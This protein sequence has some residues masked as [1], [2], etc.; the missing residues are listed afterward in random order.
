MVQAPEKISPAEWRRLA[1]GREK[2]HRPQFRGGQRD[3]LPGSVDSAW[4]ANV[5]RILLLLQQAGDVLEIEREPFEFS[6]PL[7][8][9]TNYYLPDFRVVFCDSGQDGLSIATTRFV[10]VKG[11][12]TSKGKTQLKR[13]AKYYPEIF[14][15]MLF[16]VRRDPQ[17]DSTLGRR[18][19][20]TTMHSFLYWIG[21]RRFW[22]YQDLRKQFGPLIA[23]E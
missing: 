23:W 18:R 22:F 20:K 2:P 14:R 21:A 11:Y 9:G 5:W 10:E 12:P 4:E 8:R 1:R 19:K 7:D 17:A 6:F 3:D 15:D 13:M 16:V